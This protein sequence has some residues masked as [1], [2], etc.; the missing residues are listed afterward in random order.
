[1]GLVDPKPYVYRFIFDQYD[2]NDTKILQYFVMNGLG[3]CIKLNSYVSHMFYALAFIHNIEVPID[4]KQNKYNIPLNTYN[5]D[6]SWGDSNS[7][8]NIT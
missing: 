5:I 1:M 3:L 6:F 2:S 7:N 4:V 8:K